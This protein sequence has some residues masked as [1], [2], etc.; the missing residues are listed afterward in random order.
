MSQK[1]E[2]IPSIKEQR[3]GRCVHFNGLMN[4]A[5]KA[6]VLY[7]ETFTEPKEQPL[8]YRLPCNKHMAMHA[9]MPCL[10]QKFPTP[11]EVEAE[12]KIQLEFT[13]KTLTVYATV[14]DYIEKNPT[15]QSGK[16]KCP[17]GD[18]D[19]AFAVA[20]TNGHVWFRC[21]TCQIGGNE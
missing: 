7:H 6:G 12:E 10:H 1:K 13:A 4:A 8:M 9:T 19:M 5:C 17:H 14:K 15:V 11:E 18:H 16:I 20:K 3:A 21:V 2:N